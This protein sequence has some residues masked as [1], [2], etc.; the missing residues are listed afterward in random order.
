MPYKVDMSPHEFAAMIQR[1]V[2]KERGATFPARVYWWWIADL[3]IYVS[4][5]AICLV[6]PESVS[7]WIF[8]FLVVGMF[9]FT[10]SAALTVTYYF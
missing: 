8:G 6:V 2:R 10:G 9:V 3:V 5:L 4:L 7:D 1:R